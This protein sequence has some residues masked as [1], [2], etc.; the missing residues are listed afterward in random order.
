MRPAR[1][2]SM[3]I[4]FR[5]RPQVEQLEARD[6]PSIYYV[7][8]GGLDT[9]NGGSTTPWATLQHAANVLQSGDTVVVRAGSYKGFDMSNSGTASSPITF[10]ADPGVSVTSPETMRGK[11]GINLE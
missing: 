7:A 4:R 5:F 11:D 6:T 9:S 10:K 2:V 3:R 1:S 8:P